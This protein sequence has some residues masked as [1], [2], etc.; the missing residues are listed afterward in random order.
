MG[1]EVIAL[2]IVSACLVYVL[3]LKLQPGETVKTRI[4]WVASLLLF[5]LWALTRLEPLVSHFPFS[6]RVRLHSLGS[7][8]AGMAFGIWLALYVLC[9][10]SVPVIRRKKPGD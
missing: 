10:E 3:C 2:V 5:M 8:F 6:A 7:Q 9:K 1:V 4:L